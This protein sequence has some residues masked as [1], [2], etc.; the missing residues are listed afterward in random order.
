MISL[1]EFKKL[2]AKHNVIPIV[3]EK[4]ADFETPISIA[5]R[6]KRH[7]KFFLLESIEGGE[8]WGRYSILGYDIAKEFVIDNGVATLKSGDLETILPGNPMD[9]LQGYLR[10]Y[11]ACHLA[12][13]PRFFGGAVGYF[14]FESVQ[15]FERCGK[16]KPNDTR[17]PDA[18]FL[19]ADHLF[20]FESML[21]QYQSH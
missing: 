19:I 3:R 21:C 18:E 8:R 12:G 15:Y 1:T 2:A 10:Q 6:L 20:V 16:V 11:K 4:V 17:F 7:G 9:A 13:L 5:A 14:A